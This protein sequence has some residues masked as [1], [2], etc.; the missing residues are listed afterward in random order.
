MKKYKY[1]YYKIHPGIFPDIIKICFSNDQFQEILKDYEI[2]DKSVALQTGIAET[3]FIQNAYVGLIIGVFNLAEM[4]DEVPSVSGTIA[5]E[6]SHIVDRM[7][8]YIG[9]EHIT[10]EVRAYFTQ[11]L[12]E[13]I[14]LCIAEERKKNAREQNR[15]LSRQA[16]QEKRR[17]KPKMDKHDNG[18]AGS[19]SVPQQ[20][21]APSGA[22]VEYWK[23]IAKTDNSV[24][25]IGRA[26]VSG[27]ANKLP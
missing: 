21:N 18:S 15:E 11:F 22:E 27:D 13:N 3:H 10:D 19:N 6:A 7:A 16:S 1:C 5:H 2:K 8:E 26:G 25:T 17:A 23:N 4:G 9:Q 20:T 12:V 14:W 24:S